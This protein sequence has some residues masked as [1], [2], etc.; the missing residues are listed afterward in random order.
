MNCKCMRYV[1]WLMILW[2]S[3]PNFL[4]GQR[5]TGV[6]TIISDIKGGSG[7]YSSPYVLHTNVIE[8]RIDDTYG[9]GKEEATYLTDIHLARHRSCATLKSFENLRWSNIEGRTFR[10]EPMGGMYYI[11]IAVDYNGEEVDTKYY[12]QCKVPPI[13]SF[14]LPY[15]PPS[16]NQRPV[17]VLN[18][19]NAVG[20]VGS[21]DDPY[22]I[23]SPIVK[24]TIDGSYDPDGE[25]DI[26]Y[27]VQY[28][29][30]YMEGHHPVYCSE[31]EGERDPAKTFLYYDDFQG[32]VYQWDTRERPSE[33]KHYRFYLCVIDQ[34]GEQT[35]ETI[36]F[37]YDPDTSPDSPELKVNPVQLDFAH[38]ST[39]MYF[40]VSNI[41]TGTLTWSASAAQVQ[42]WLTA[43][44]P[45]NG[46][47]YAGTDKTV[48]VTVDGS[49]L[50]DGEYH[51][52]IS[53]TS[54]GGNNEVEVYMKVTTPPEPPKNVQISM[55]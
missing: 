36:R 3:R 44:T 8:W 34:Y 51:E 40:T 45:G 33:D 9:P 6:I 47:L 32:T 10:V 54:N 37:K 49:G 30:I 25:D 2:F 50:A 23:N 29:S 12:V 19:I 43:I 5:P 53:V 22:I 17:P 52:T 31:D 27:G 14:T 35:D 41:G 11:K 21:Y 48:E 55:P 16:G 39:T 13:K 18:V 4:W 20:G 7:S 38:K 1:V 28:W 26:R 46:N 24:F 15:Q 42:P